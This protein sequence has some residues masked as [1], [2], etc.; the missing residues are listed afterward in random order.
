MTRRPARLTPSY[1]RNENLELC[2]QLRSAGFLRP[3]A[4]ISS[5]TNDFAESTGSQLHADLQAEFAA[6]A[7]EYFP[8]L[9]AA[10]WSLQERL[11]LRLP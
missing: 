11:E 3:V 9:R 5:N 7:L 8:S 2:S 4:F 6:V 10:F 1:L